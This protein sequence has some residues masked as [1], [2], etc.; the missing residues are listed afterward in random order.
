MVPLIDGR[1]DS[2]ESSLPHLVHR[3]EWLLDQLQGHLEIGAEEGGILNSRAT[4]AKE[5]TESEDQ[6]LPVSDRTMELHDCISGA[7]RVGSDRGKML[8]ILLVVR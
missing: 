4:D 1:L 5:Q 7:C 3:H 8:Q 2:L 6:Q